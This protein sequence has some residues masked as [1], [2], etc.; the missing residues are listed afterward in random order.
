[1]SATQGNDTI[2]GTAAND[3]LDGLGGNDTIVAFGGK[4]TLVGG[5]GGDLLNG[6]GGVD[7]ARYDS[8]GAAVHVSIFT[9]SGSAWGGDAT[10]DTLVGIENLAGSAFDDALYGDNGRNRI[11]GNGG[12]DLI[13]G[14]GGG[15]D[16]FGGSGI[17]RLVGGAGADVLNGGDG[18]DTADYTSSAQGIL[19]D[20]TNHQAVGGDAQ[21]DTLVSIEK[22]IGSGQAD[23]LLGDG[24][25]NFLFGS[26]GGDF[27]YGRGGADYLDGGANDDRLEGGA[28]GDDLTGGS[29]ADEFACTA[30]GQSQVGAIDIIRDFSHAQGDRI[31]LSNIDAQ[32]HALGDQAFVFRGTGLI[33]GEG[34]IRFQQADGDTFVYANTSSAPGAEIV[35]KLDGLHDLTASDFI[36]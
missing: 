26:S 19:I 20:F 15:D 11:E 4:D 34:Q 27:L 18:F 35:I 16:L 7:T 17:D 29:G 28:G 10:G 36:L 24:G 22:I 2:Y 6:G 14:Y 5:A 1:M 9:G 30:L 31:D 23:H 33:T 25:A 13:Y 32:A 8:S 21:N 12:A 3:W